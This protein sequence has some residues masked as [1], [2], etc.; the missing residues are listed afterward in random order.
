LM[1]GGAVT[2]LAFSRDGTQLISGSDDG[3]V[4]V[5][6][7]RTGGFAEV[8]VSAAVTSVA[9]R[10]DA[11]FMAV[12]A[13]DA[14][15]WNISKLDESVANPTRLGDGS[16]QVMVVGFGGDGSLLAT[17]GDD[18]T[19]RLWLPIDELIE[20]ACQAAGR[21]LTAEEWEEFAPG[22]PYATTCNQWPAG[23]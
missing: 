9:L 20:I 15:L 5:W 17:G 1:H 2:S 8:D 16:D 6:D 3:T 13:G 7:L 10:A 22:Q 11:E 19:V 12:A 23:S 21:N 14:Q 18:D 4:R